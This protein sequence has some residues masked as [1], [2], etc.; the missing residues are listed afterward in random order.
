MPQ[1]VANNKCTLATP[2]VHIEEFGYTVDINPD[3]ITFPKDEII[4]TG[5]SEAFQDFQYAGN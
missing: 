3:G 1:N 2:V 4:L 5:Y